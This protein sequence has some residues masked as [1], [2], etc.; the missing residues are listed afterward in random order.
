MINDL[1]RLM[2]EFKASDLHL[3]VNFPPAYRI[4]GNIRPLTE[5]AR[6]NLDI[7]LNLINTLTMEDTE[8]MAKAIMSVEQWEKFIKIGELDF[9]YSLPEVGRFRVNVFRQRGA[10]AL[11]LRHINSKI[12]SFKELGLPEV[13]ADLS[14]KNRGIVLVT[15]PTG[16]G[17]STTLASMIDLINSERACHII[18]LE[19]PIEYLHNHKKS[20]VNQREIGSDSE[21]FAKALRAAMREDPDVILVGEM[22]DL[23]TISIAITAAETGHLVFATLHTSSAAETIDRIIDVF[24]PSQ[25]QQIR[26]QLST[27]IQG[28]IAQQLIPRMDGKGRVVAV[29]IMVAT[30]AIRNLIREG[31]THQIPAQI[32]TGA[33]YGM[34][35]LDMAL[36]KLYQNRL[37]SYEEVVSRA[38]DAESLAR[39]LY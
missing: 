39:M 28:I 35:T 19:D 30:P 15:G 14:R 8:A 20:I 7:P 27:T 5:L 21:S 38:H 26:V 29:E 9:A 12:L 13:I 34:Q 32:Q 6:E 33:K 16:S 11:V 22:R 18:T 24:P 4:H 17:K 10:V 31:K 2:V 25:Q 23:E 1:L 36:A 37:I 3:T